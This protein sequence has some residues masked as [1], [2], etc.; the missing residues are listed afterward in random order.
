[1]DFNRSR[2]RCGLDNVILNKK[3][4]SGSFLIPLT[5][6]SDG[7]CVITGG[8]VYGPCADENAVGDEITRHWPNG[9]APLLLLVDGHLIEEIPRQPRCDRLPAARGLVFEIKQH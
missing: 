7:Y 4:R 6:T 2:G 5:K 8:R 1:M 3:A 9:G